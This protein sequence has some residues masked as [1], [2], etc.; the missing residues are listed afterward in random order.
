MAIIHLESN[1]AEAYP[2][3]TYCRL[4]KNDKSPVVLSQSHEGV[5]LFMRESNYYDDSDFYMTVWNEEKGAPE[6]ILYASTRGWCE[7]CFYSRPDATEEVWEKYRNWEKKVAEED[8]L[9]KIQQS[10]ELLC[11]IRTSES[12]VKE[13][14]SLDDGVIIKLRK[15][16]GGWVNATRGDYEAVLNLLSNKRIR[17]KFKLNLREQV[18]AWIDEDSPKYSTPLSPRQLMYI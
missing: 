14:Y 16:Y 6:T 1:R 17:S 15:A 5:C 11:G 2:A 10:V 8:N 13:M 7:P 18:L 12:K 3:G 4:N 9:R